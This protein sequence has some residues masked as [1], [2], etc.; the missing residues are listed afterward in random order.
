MDNNQIAQA[1]FT[2]REAFIEQQRKER[3]AHGGKPKEMTEQEK[4]VIVAISNL[5]VNFLQNLNDISYATVNMDSTFAHR[6]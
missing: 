6:Q 4:K 2:I 5:A 1:V 3:Q